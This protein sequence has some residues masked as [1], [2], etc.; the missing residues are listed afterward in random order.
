MKTTLEIP[1]SIYR[2]AKARASGQGIPFRQFVSE[3][4]IEKLKSAAGAK[5]RIRLVGGLRHLRRE[6][7]RINRRIEQEFENVG[8]EE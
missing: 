1:D 7:S 3:A 2:R 4:V 6:S 5:T 8:P